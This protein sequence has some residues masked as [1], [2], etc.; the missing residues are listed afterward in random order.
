MSSTDRRRKALRLARRRARKAFAMEQPG[1]SAL[2]CLFLRSYR[3]WRAQAYD[4]LTALG[5]PEDGGA[6]PVE[7]RTGIPLVWFGDRW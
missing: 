3:K 6:Y 1:P 5:H 4:D 2:W 7:R